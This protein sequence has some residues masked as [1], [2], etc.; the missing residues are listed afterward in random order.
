[1]AEGCGD[2]IIKSDGGADAGGN[3]VLADVGIF[4]KDQITSHCKK[5]KI[6]ITVKYIDPTYMIRSVPPNAKDSE[7]CSLL[8]QQ[9]VHVAMA[10]YTGITVG[11]VDQRFVTLPIHAITNKG[12]RK[13]SLDSPDFEQL[14]STT[15]QPRFDP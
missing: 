6:P 9:A 13:V 2:T 3:K 12:Q 1:M 5:N 10:G 8:A 4:M 11:K 14:M 15:L 7:L